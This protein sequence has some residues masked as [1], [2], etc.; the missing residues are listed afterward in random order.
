[1]CPKKIR[2]TQ[3][4]NSNGETYFSLSNI[5]RH[6][7]LHAED[8]EDKPPKKSR[9]PKEKKKGSAKFQARKLRSKESSEC[10]VNLEELDDVEYEVL[11][12][13]DEGGGGS[14]D[15]KIVSKRKIPTRKN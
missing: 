7:K 8:K 15:F 10:D 6:W 5:E 14:E 3:Q 13:D 11:T 2:A 12:D 9:K 1:M 4:Q